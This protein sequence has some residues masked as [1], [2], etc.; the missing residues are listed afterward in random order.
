MYYML[1]SASHH[2]MLFAFITKE[3]V[4]EFH[5]LGENAIENG[6]IKYG[7]QR[8]QRMALRTKADG[9]ELNVMNYL[10]YGEWEALPGQMDLRFP[11]F[12]PEVKMQNYKCP[13]HT[14]WSKRGL[15]KYGKLYCKHVDSALA[16]G[17]KSDMNLCLKSTRVE[18][19]ECC[20]FLFKG[21]SIEDKDQEL[22]KE[23]KRKIGNKAKMPWEYHVGH[24]YK[25]LRE[26][27]LEELGPKCEEAFKRALDLYEKEYGQKSKNLVIEYQDIDY[28]VMPPYE[29]I[30]E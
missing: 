18:D 5:E 2:A 30:N 3:I 11:E 13:W 21:Q 9:N 22:F 27:A 8:G 10:V 15:I 7:Y 28:N 25:T 17:Y 1:S 24:L 20:D 26:V 4:E 23:L 29:G 6:V 19:S 16:K 14:E 12:N